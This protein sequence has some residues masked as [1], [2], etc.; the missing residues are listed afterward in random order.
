MLYEDAR[1]RLHPRSAGPAEGRYN[2][3]HAHATRPHGKPSP[4]PGTPAAVP[5]DPS[6]ARRTGGAGIA[7]AEPRADRGARLT[8]ATQLRDAHRAAAGAA[9]PRVAHLVAREPPE[10]GAQFRLP[11]QRLQRLPAAAVRLPDRSE[12][13]RVGKECRTR[14]ST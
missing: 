8:A 10:R 13:R 2:G 14:W 6:R 7:H 11:A 9:A 3:P 4:R 5:A 1:P 12:E